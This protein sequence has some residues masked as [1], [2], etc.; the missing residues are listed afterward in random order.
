MIEVRVMPLPTTITKDDLTV[1][2]CELFFFCY[3]S[4]VIELSNQPIMWDNQINGFLFPPVLSTVFLVSKSSKAGIFLCNNYII[5]SSFRFYY[6][7]WSLCQIS[8][9]MVIMFRLLRSVHSQ[10]LF[11]CTSSTGVQYIDS[12]INTEKE[13]FEMVSLH[14]IKV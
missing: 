8:K 7:A 2:L 5:I 14:H 10:L 11:F 13:H 4:W 9:C 1:S 12:S 3:Y 6:C